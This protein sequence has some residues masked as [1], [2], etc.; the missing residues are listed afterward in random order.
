MVLKAG[1][2]LLAAVGATT[3]VVVVASSGS[4]GEQAVVT[5]VVDGDTVDVTAG[6]RTE[7]VRLLNI[8]T[9]EVTE[10]DVQCLG[11]EASAHLAALLP[12]G[13]PVTLEFDEER[14]DGYGR[15]LAG[16]LTE[17]G[18]LVNAEM[19]RAGLAMPIV[20]GENDRFYDAVL[21]ARDEAAARD[22]GLFSPEVECTVPARVATVAATVAGTQAAPG[23]SA[24][25]LESAASAAEEALGAVQALEETLARDPMGPVWGVFSPDEQTGLLDDVRGA[26][27]RAE[28]HADTLHDAAA[29]A[30]AREEAARQAEEQR[31]ARAAEE[32][33]QVRIAEERRQAREAEERRR[34]SDDAARRS[35]PDPEPPAASNPYP[36]YTGP[37]CYAPG[38][39]TWK[40]C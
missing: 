6:G 2:A 11:P 16:V 4:S 35:A 25:E 37:R 22:R 40:P 38:G 18:T 29:A 5:K 19:A 24:T 23:T 10:P 30:K 14:I 33:R 13:T 1:A 17:D 7:R 12:V 39:K 8:D 15:T 27:T 32:Q 34:E 21:A 9:P 31:R 20:I 36:G 26:L 28:S 3:A